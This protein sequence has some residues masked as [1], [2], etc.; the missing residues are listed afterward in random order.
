MTLPKTIIR[1]KFY[2]EWH[3]IYDHHRKSD[4]FYHDHGT[5][6]PVVDI[7]FNNHT[8][9]ITCDGEMDFH[10]KDVHV[11]SYDDLIAAGI[12]TDLDWKELTNDSYFGYWGLYPWFDAYEYDE[13]KKDWV[14]LDMVN[15]D[16][17]DIIRE[18]QKY[19]IKITQKV[20]A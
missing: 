14:H 11:R 13:D 19:M 1:N 20:S 7:T 9:Q 3:Q 15:G 8:V 10:V 5:C 6:S 17:D 16:I 2:F 12:K 18:V 4:I